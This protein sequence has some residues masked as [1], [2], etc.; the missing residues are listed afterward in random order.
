[1]IYVSFSDINPRRFDAFV[2]QLEKDPEGSIHKLID[3]EGRCVIA[4]LV[5]NRHIIK[6]V[7]DNYVVDVESNRH[8][9]DCESIKNLTY[10]I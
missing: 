10:S 6:S 8:S 2:T 5:D 9:Y 4:G 3:D 1:M 7:K